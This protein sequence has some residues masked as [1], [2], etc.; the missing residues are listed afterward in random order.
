MRLV[1]KGG[2]AAPGDTDEAKK[3]A[4]KLRPP[5]PPH[6]AQRAQVYDEQ[7]Q[8]NKLQLL[9]GTDSNQAAE[10]PQARKKNRTECTRNT[11]DTR[12]I[13]PKYSVPWK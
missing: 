6:L 3:R 11:R 13:K 7:T 1:N 8:I 2:A 5:P 9:K 4:K 10:I 12:V